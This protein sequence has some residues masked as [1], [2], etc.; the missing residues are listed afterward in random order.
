MLRPAGARVKLLQNAVASERGSCGRLLAYI[1]V[2][3]QDFGS[4]LV[5]QG[6]A[7]VYEEGD[8]SKE[9]DYLRLQDQ[10]QAEGLGLWGC[11]VGLGPDAPPPSGAP[12][13]NCDPSY[14]DVCIPPK[15]PDLNCGDIP[16][17]RFTV[18]Q[19]DPHKFDGDKDG[20]GCES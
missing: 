1:L 14:P 19:P 2:G 4:S 17:K 18:L 16:Y 20:I 3:D 12:D 13:G 8:S 7:R 10:A 9:Q 11:A 15:P 6:Y 5:A